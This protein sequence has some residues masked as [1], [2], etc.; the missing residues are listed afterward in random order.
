MPQIGYYTNAVV[1]MLKNELRGLTRIMGYNYR[2]NRYF[3]Y[4]ER[5]MRVDRTTNDL[6]A[7]GFQRSK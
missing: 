4:M 3:T 5:I 7:G 2:N 6:L 1:S